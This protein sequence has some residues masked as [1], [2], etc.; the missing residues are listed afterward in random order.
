MK[1]KLCFFDNVIIRIDN[2]IVGCTQVGIFKDGTAEECVF[3]IT[4]IEFAIAQVG[5]GKVGFN[6]G[7]IGVSCFLVLLFIKYSIV[8]NT[9]LKMHLEQ[10][11]I[12]LAKIHPANF[13][14]LKADILHTGIA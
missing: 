3:E 13:T 4:V 9:V 10:K 1:R 8:Q 2:E 12:G 6:H 14:M 7:A 5:F 11:I